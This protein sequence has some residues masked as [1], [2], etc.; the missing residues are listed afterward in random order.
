MATKYIY[1][2]LML[3]LAALAFGT[4]LWSLASVDPAKEAITFV[5]ALRVGDLRKVVRHYDGKTCRCPE[6]GGWATF[7]VYQSDKQPNLA[8]LLGL[9]FS[10]GEPT[11]KSV[12]KAHE[13]MFPWQRPDDAIV[14]IPLTF[15]AS[16]YSPLFL[17]LPLAFGNDM[18]EKELQEFLRDPIVNS[19]SAFTLRL[20][21]SLK[22][23][24]L[25]ENVDKVDAEVF[26]NLPKSQEKNKEEK[27]KISEITKIYR[28]RLLKA[29]L[30][31]KKNGYLHPADAGQ[32]IDSSGKVIPIDVLERQ[33]PRLKS[34]ILSIHL[35]RDDQLQ[36][37]AMYRCAFAKP[38]ITLDNGAKVID[39]VPVAKTPLRSP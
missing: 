5:E 2:L 30:E 21:P 13:Y 22:P 19:G 12:V 24:L 9:P 7:L 16:K 37:W 29:A 39:F 23:G 17:P 33:L 15:D 26:I 10:I 1:P 32:V 6:Q 27:A 34:I 14:N 4:W 18:S 20:R 35:V 3:V 25:K 8:F 31:E 38:Q 28:E 36:N 11:R